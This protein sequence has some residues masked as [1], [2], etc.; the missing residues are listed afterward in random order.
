M[1]DVAAAAPAEDA[2]RG[3]VV[4]NVVSL[5]A[6]QASNSLLPLLTYP[7]LTRVL[8]V[9]GYGEFGFSFGIA[10]YAVLVTDW[11]F[12]LSAS[13]EVAR[14]RDDPE[15]LSAIVWGTLAAK[16]LLAF[17]SLAALGVAAVAIPGLR[18][19]A[20]VL[21]G[22]AGMVVANVLTVY[23]CLQGLERLGRFAVAALLCRAAV[24][25]LTFLLVRDPGDAWLAAA[26]L[27]G[28]GIAAGL[29][30]LLLLWRLQLIRP[31][32]RSDLDVGARI[33]SSWHLFLANASANLYTTTNVVLVG[34]LLGPVAAGLYTAADRLRA[35][36]QNVIQPISQAAYPRS[37][38]LMQQSREAG[39]AFARQVLLA[40]VA[41]T[42]MVSIVLFFGAP[43]IIRL[44]AG[45]GYDGS[46]RVLQ[47]MAPMPALIGISDSLGVQVLLPLGLKARF[48]AIRVQA[49]VLNLVVVAGLILA[50]GVTGAA[51]GTVIAEVFILVSML[52]VAHGRGFVLFAS[53][54]PV[55]E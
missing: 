10:A 51:L 12:G 7:Y 50:L 22:A 47:V 26:L 45:E 5:A 31:P 28:G 9:R 35:A 16:A 34:A 29:V 11:G 43:L 42:G 1:S 53:R 17:G 21:A 32:A 3:L 19:M 30:S 15:R 20:P 46:V 27:S 55:A 8:D 36:A 4:R 24:V 37:T 25:P 18:P 39:F 44:L 14:H 23:W 41:V 54:R 13:G 33:R 2:R 38:R 49:G 40:Q 48:S 52:V 6:W